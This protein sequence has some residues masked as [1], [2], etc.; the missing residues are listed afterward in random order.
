MKLDQHNNT[1]SHVPFKEYLIK[2]CKVTTQSVSLTYIQRETS[3][4][5]ISTPFS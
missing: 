5:F 1:S 2:Y 4:S 3:D